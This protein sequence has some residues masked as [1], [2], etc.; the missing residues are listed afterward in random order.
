MAHLFLFPDC[1]TG[2]GALTDSVDKLIGGTVEAMG[3]EVVRI[4][5]MGSRAR[6]VLQVM[7][8]AKDE[9]P[10]TVD[11]CADVSRAVSAL[12]DEADLI[13]GAYTLEVTSPG[14]DRPLTRLKDFDRFAGLEARVETDLPI[15]GRKRFK[16]RLAG[17][18]GEAVRIVLPEGE[19]VI[20]FADIRRAKLVLTDE[21]LSVAAAG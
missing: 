12:L 21:L 9:R 14:I 5:M 19:V 17:T 8:E 16:G 3:Y 4:A 18:E 11:D 2:A 13:D 1:C 7:I 10:L 20:A 6:P 15:D